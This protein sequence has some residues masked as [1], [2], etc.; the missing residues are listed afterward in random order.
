[1]A[2]VAVREPSRARRDEE[3]PLK[4]RARRSLK[5]VARAITPA[6]AAQRRSL[7]IA[8]CQRSGTT[9]LQQSILDRSWRVI[10]LGEMDPK[11]V[12][13]TA[14]ETLRWRPLT[15]VASTLRA[16]PFE[17]VVV[18]PLAESHRTTQL[19]DALPNSKAIWMLRHY[20]SVATSNLAKFGSDNGHR[21]LAK[22]VS[23][24][25]REW[26]ARSSDDVR[27]RI[28][29]LMNGELSDLDAAALFWWARN[30]LYFD[31]KLMEDDRVRVLRYEA[32][33]NDP[34][35]CVESISKY[36]GVPLP[37]HSGERAIRRSGR[38]KEGLR[39]EVED[40]CAEM[41]HRFSGVPELGPLL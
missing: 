27:E 15:E 4:R 6:A 3:P 24:D 34:G 1:M 17:L 7:I 26:R 20:L 16:L 35:G 25:S 32:V 8:G 10:A 12:R 41:L 31:Q 18:K 14:S 29:A 23:G 40:L 19:L 30:H 21:D 13:D 33:I 9:M 38:A 37:P 11:L 28:R 22:L 2:S 36:V 39:P 5:H